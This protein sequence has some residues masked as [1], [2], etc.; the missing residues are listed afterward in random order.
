MTVTGMRCIEGINNLMKTFKE[1]FN[2]FVNK[3]NTNE[4]FA[5]TRFGDGEMMLLNRQHINL[6]KKGVGEFEYDGNPVYDRSIELLKNAYTADIDNY[7]VGIACPCCVGNDKSASMKK[8]TG[9]SDDKLTW[10]NIFVNANY[11]HTVD[12]IIPLIK[13]REHD[14]VLV[15]HEKSDITNLPWTQ[16]RSQFYPIKSNAWVENIDLIDIISDV[17]YKGK[18]MLICAGP[19]ANILAH[20]LFRRNNRN[21]YID[22]GSVLDPYLNLPITRGYQLG[23]ATVN[24]VCIWE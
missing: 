18:I 21:T 24:K 23:A 5:L 2:K 12:T 3:L 15:S 1:D 16:L 22:F 6:M 9:L 11:P 4:N 13:K 10:A 8:G 7:F 19:F 14:I 17:E 20:E